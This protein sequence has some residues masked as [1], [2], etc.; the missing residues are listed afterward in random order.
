MKLGVIRLNIH[1]PIKA[2]VF[3]RV[4][5]LHYWSG[6]RLR[7][8]QTFGVLRFAVNAGR[9]QTIA[10]IRRVYGIVGNVDPAAMRIAWNPILAN[11]LREGKIIAD[12][13][14]ELKI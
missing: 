5:I 1:A 14:D 4:T 2:I 13:M 6:E 10:I 11:H 7:F 8:R 9:G 12:K 3:L